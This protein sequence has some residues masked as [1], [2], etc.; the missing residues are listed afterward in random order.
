MSIK[1]IY[2]T[3]YKLLLWIPIVLVVL[4]FA[5]IGMQYSQTGDFVNKGISLKGGS[6]FTLEELPAMSGE[7]LELLLQEQFPGGDITVRSLSSGGSIVGLSVDSDAQEQAEIDVVLN[8]IVQQTGIGKE[9]ISVEV[10][11]SS[12]GENFFKQTFWALIFAFLLMGFVVSIYF[13]KLVPS[14]TVVASAFSDIV[15]TLAIFNLT[16]IPLSSAGVAAFLMIIGYSVDTDILLNTRLLKRKEGTQVERVYS[17]MKTGLTMTA[18]T[19]MAVVVS[20]I[21]VQSEVIKQIMIILAIGLVVDTLMTYIFNVG[22]LRLYLE[23]KRR[24]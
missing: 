19:L 21:F 11:G 20:I 3:K 8:A 12:L 13:R 1:R 18:T 7:E 14:L 4:A 9:K 24:R 10:T 2:E 5:Q 6:T 16:N 17:S 23:K 22:I 15:I